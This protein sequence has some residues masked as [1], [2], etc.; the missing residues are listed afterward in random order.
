MPCE[1]HTS[2]VFLAQL[3]RDIVFCNGVSHSQ[4]NTSEMFN[5]FRPVSCLTT[6]RNFLGESGF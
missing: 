4:K 6:L 5:E 1:K 3:P 2:C